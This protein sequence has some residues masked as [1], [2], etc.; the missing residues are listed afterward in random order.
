MSSNARFSGAE[1]LADAD[2]WH[3]YQQRW[4]LW[5]AC[6]LIWRPW[7]LHI[8]GCFTSVGSIGTFIE[9]CCSQ[10]N[11]HCC[12]QASMSIWSRDRPGKDHHQDV[13]G[14]TIRHLCWALQTASMKKGLLD[15]VQDWCPLMLDADV[16]GGGPGGALEGVLIWSTTPSSWTSLSGQI[17][18]VP[19]RRKRFG[20]LPILPCFDPCFPKR[21]V[22]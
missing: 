6:P 16:G 11:V 21:L 17:W 10:P 12:P 7:Y 13:V 15:V 14:S 20:G 9:R 18:P 4:Q 1:E 8:L 3:G 5:M 2:K 22:C 19:R